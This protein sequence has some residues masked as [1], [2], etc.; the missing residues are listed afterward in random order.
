MINNHNFTELKFN[1]IN[2]KYKTLSL[3]EKLIN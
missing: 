1:F 2:D 3:Y